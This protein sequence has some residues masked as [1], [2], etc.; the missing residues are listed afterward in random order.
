MLIKSFSVSI[1]PTTL[2]VYSFFSEKILR[3]LIV[4][5]HYTW[6]PSWGVFFENLSRAKCWLSFFLSLGIPGLLCLTYIFELKKLVTD[7]Q[8]PKVI[9]LL[10]GAAM[11]F[12][13]WGFS[14]FSA[15][16][17]GRMIWLGYI[18]LI[19]LSLLALKSRQATQ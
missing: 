16:A 4:P 5:I 19:P 6:A 2:R 18:Y 11:C 3:E 12:C 17:D 8:S 10:G 7:V 9:T 1:F 14:L 15:W 13:L